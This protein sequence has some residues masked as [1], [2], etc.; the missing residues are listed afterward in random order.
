MIYFCLGPTQGISSDGYSYIETAERLLD[1]RGF[2]PTLVGTSYDVFTTTHFP[3]GLPVLMAL[4]GSTGLSVTNAALVVNWASWLASLGAASVLYRRSGG[5]VASWY[6]A[7]FLWLA[8]SALIVRQMGSVWSEPVSLA[9]SLWLLVVA[10]RWISSDRAWGYGLASVVL[11]S[12]LISVR[13]AGIL[14]VVAV[15][16]R[17]IQEGGGLARVVRR[18]AFVALSV[19]PT[20]I[21][22]LACASELRR[23]RGTSPAPGILPNVLHS[24]GGLGS[25]LGG[26]LSYSIKGQPGLGPM[27]KVTQP[28]FVA[29]GLAAV[30]AGIVFLV[31]WWY[32][33]AGRRQVGRL[34][35][36]RQTGHLLL[37]DY[38]I[39]YVVGMGL[40]RI[41]AGYSI[42]QRY[43]ILVIVPVAIVLA[44]HLSDRSQ[45]RE[46][47]VV[48]V[49]LVVIG[50]LAVNTGWSMWS[51]L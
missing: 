27:G 17:V 28:L 34:E 39:I 8:A 21:W 44:A 20:A 50:I 14:V 48:P 4:F 19:L 45:H 13:Y 36:A 18:C 25:F 40:Y 47:E 42:I 51:I 16:L 22:Y 26:G 35:R 37:V 9:L 41:P 38:V 7:I 33:S 3:P 24:G 10:E 46:R 31:F 29:I 11:G 12:V 32:R 23:A 15:A 43:W 5:Q 30:L 6:S 1:G 2:G 49:G